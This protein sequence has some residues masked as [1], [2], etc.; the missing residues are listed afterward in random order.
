MHHRPRDRSVFAS[1][2]KKD[3][4]S[5]LPLAPPVILKSV[6]FHQNSLGV[7]ELKEILDNPG[8]AFPAQGLEAVVS[9]KLDVGRDDPVDL[10][11]G[12]AEHDVFTGTFEVIV[13]DLV[14]A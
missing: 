11:R 4:H 12:S 14:G 13:D 10:R 2:G 5:V 6:S 1:D 7:F 9:A 3:T 8:I